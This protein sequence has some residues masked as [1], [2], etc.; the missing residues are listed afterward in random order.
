MDYL[1]LFSPH[2]LALLSDWLEETG[3]LYTNIE[4]PHSGGS[5]DAYFIHSM[6]DFKSLISQQTWSEI[7][8]TVFHHLQ[9]SLRGAANEELLKQALDL[10]PDGE[11][12]TIFA[13]DDLFPSPPA[14]GSGSSHEEFRSE[15]ADILGKTIRI[16]QN[17]FDIRD[18]DYFFPLTD[19]VFEVHMLRSNQFAVVK[20]QD[21]YAPFAQN[22]EK[23]QSLIDLWQ[24]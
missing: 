6:S 9:Y 5:G 12:Y 3:E 17:P 19:E 4:W 15:F 11:W 20:N 22:P 10:I 18:F 7:D 8:I 23:Y 1:T 16:G 21:F 13:L 2:N 24:Q 14:L